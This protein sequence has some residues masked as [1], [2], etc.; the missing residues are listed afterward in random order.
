MKI[1]REQDKEVGHSLK[2]SLPLFLLVK[3]GVSLPTQG[4]CPYLHC[5]AL[6]PSVTCELASITAAPS[7]LILWLLLNS[8]HPFYP[9]RLSPLHHLLFTPLLCPTAL[10]HPG[11][12]PAD[13]ALI[14]PGHF[15]SHLGLLGHCSL[16]FS[17]PYQLPLPP[18]FHVPTALCRS[19]LARRVL[20]S[21]L[22]AFA[23]Q[24]QPGALTFGQ[25]PQF[26]LQLSLFSQ[27]LDSSV[28]LSPRHLYW[29]PTCISHLSG[30]HEAYIS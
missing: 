10:L 12:L 8:L 24:F 5:G 21:L 3:K 11:P 18:F 27:I 28:Q 26:Y 14:H 22:F 19:A 25:L 20:Y 9:H 4:S 30:P 6:D 23:L 1:T 17:V 15:S 13:I 7:L 29:M 16:G 2:P